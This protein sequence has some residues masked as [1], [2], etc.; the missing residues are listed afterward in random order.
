MHNLNNTVDIY[1][2]KSASEHDI[3]YS[4][5]MISS[6]K[7]TNCIGM[8]RNGHSYRHKCRFTRTHAHEYPNR[9]FSIN[10]SWMLILLETFILLSILTG[11]GAMSSSPGGESEGTAVGD[12]QTSHNRHSVKSSRFDPVVKIPTHGAAG[13]EYFRVPNANAIASDNA[14]DNLNTNAD[15]SSE[16]KDADSHRHYLAVSNFMATSTA[17][18]G[19]TRVVMESE[20][21]LYEIGIE[22]KKRVTLGDSSDNDYNE[23]SFDGKKEILNDDMM[24][25]QYKEVQR[26]ATNGAHG[27]DHL[28]VRSVNDFGKETETVFLAIPNFYGTDTVLYQYELG[29]VDT[30]TN[31]NTDVDPEKDN[32]M[33]ADA[34]ADADADEHTCNHSSSSKPLMNKFREHQRIPT[35]GAAAIEFF[36][37]QNA[38]CTSACT[39]TNLRHM[40]AIAEY[41]SGKVSIYEYV[42]EEWVLNQRLYAPGTAALS[43]MTIPLRVHEDVHYSDDGNGQSDDDNDDDDDSPPPNKTLL[44]TASYNVKGEWSTQS[45]VFEYDYD[46]S[47]FVYS[48]LLDTV[49][50]HGIATLST[51]EGI[52]Q[53]HFAFYANDKNSTSTLQRSALYEYVPIQKQQQQRDNHGYGY[54][55]GHGMQQDHEFV[56]RQEIETD[57]AHGATFVSVNGVYFLVVAEFGDRATRRYTRSSTVYRLELDLDLDTSRSGSAH[58]VPYTELPTEGATDFESFQMDG[59]TWLVVSNEQNESEGID[60]GSTIWRVDNNEDDDIEGDVR[61]SR[62]SIS[63]EEIPRQPRSDIKEE[64]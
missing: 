22:Y 5:E 52:G 24:H 48:H 9:Y 42:S 37:I 49:G 40:L 33:D 56:L 35:Q 20:S 53:R 23:R 34:D 17:P 3:L 8:C 10:L 4:E 39:Q 58:L 59:N 50:A 41:K 63:G 29:S 36:T 45:Q 44:L 38:A 30:D 60:I 28:T 1:N 27:V 2:R 19:S 61:D 12:G 15:E 51:Q 16:N 21:V 57:G 46:E 18:D 13:W 31:K 32:D 47:V 14:K 7:N 54:G 55:Y 25:L 6:G 11:V 43:V 64:L 26:F 62:F